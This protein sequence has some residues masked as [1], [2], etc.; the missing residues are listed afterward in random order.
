[1]SLIDAITAAPGLRQFRSP[2]SFD[3]GP[4]LRDIEPG[5]SMQ[6]N[7]E[8]AE[9]MGII[10]D[11][12]EATPCDVF[13]VCHQ[14]GSAGAGKPLFSQPFASTDH[15]LALSE[16]G[17][18]IN[19]AGQFLLGMLLDEEARPLSAVP[20]II[21]LDDAD[22]ETCA[23]TQVNY[24][25]NLPSYPMTAMAEFD[26]LDSELLN[27][28]LFARDPSIHGSGIVLGDDRMKFLDRT[29]A[30][31]SVNIIS[32]E[33]S[34][35]HAVFRWAKMTSLRSGG[36]D[37]WNL[38]YRVRRDARAGEVAWKNIGYNFTFGPDGRLETVAH[39]APIIDMVIDGK[40][41]GNLSIIFGADG[42]TQFADRGGLVKVLKATANGRI[43]SSFTGISMS[44]HGRLYAHY[45]NNFTQPIADIHFSGSE[46]WFAGGENDDWEE[47]SERR[48]A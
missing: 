48:V 37:S 38:F 45:T 23:T 43:G 14:N 21:V 25:V 3:L 27:K 18:L 8:A 39:A 46:P 44:S 24:R 28:T 47:L 5:F 31:G 42:I 7:D 40:R 41:M 22:L 11:E 17:Y 12:P 1:M 29:L 16:D 4:D 36:R 9:D 20:E 32:P 19:S 15:N 33:G 30:G 35:V 34:C 10:G 26:V 6:W 13:L 2:P